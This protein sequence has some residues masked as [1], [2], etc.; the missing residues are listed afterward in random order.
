MSAFQI[1][2]LALITMVI[3][4]VGVFLFPDIQLLRMIGR[5]SFPLFAW[6]IANGAMHTKNINNYL[7]RLLM[8]AIISQIPF[9]LAMRLVEPNFWELNIL[10]TL[11]I[12]LMAILLFQKIDNLYLK[13][14]NIVLLFIITYYLKVDY[15]VM[16]VASV[17][18]F[19]VFKNEMHII[20][21]QTVIF[22]SELMIVWL[23]MLPAGM[24]EIVTSNH[25]YQPL[26]I[27]SLIFIFLYNKKEGAKMKYFFYVFYP[28]QFVV[29]YLIKNLL[30][31]VI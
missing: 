4:H 14:L 25:Y 1:K 12:G 5:I 3:D 19:Y 6:L 10:F 17:L 7:K 23:L 31:K 29:F 26:A 2:L 22:F 13:I 16:G 8:F 30:L 11:A 20:I 15:G 21:S 28:M 9:I 27:M 18:A 24:W